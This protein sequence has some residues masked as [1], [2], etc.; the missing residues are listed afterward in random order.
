[1]AARGIDET[2]PL[3]FHSPYGCSKGCADQYVRDYARSFGL[4]TIVFRMSCIY[5]RHQFG[6]EDQG[7]VA[8]FLIRALSGR[9]I[10][11]FGDGKQVRDVLYVDDLTAAMVA[12]S[13]RADVLAGNAF[14]VGGGAQHT[15][16]LLEL[17]DMIRDIC[18]ERCEVDFQ[19]K[20]VG[21][22]PYYVSDFGK[23]TQATGWEPTTSVEEG[24]K[25][26][27]RWVREQHIVGHRVGDGPMLREREQVA[28]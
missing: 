17:L 27:A 14:N 3:D 13:E 15:V 21:D 16:S 22:Q 26:L 8:H 1:M 28:Q 18:G 5:G 6:N 10:T 23:L 20:R 19:S 24:V 4:P 2:R 12:A 9:P 7:W 25:K 11:L